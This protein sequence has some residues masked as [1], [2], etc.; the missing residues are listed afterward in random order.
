LDCN[1]SGISL[2][3]MDT[4]HVALVAMTLR[5]DGFDP[6][7]CDRNTT[8]GINLGTLSKVLKSAQNEDVLTIRTGSKPDV[9]NLT[10]ESA[11]SDRVGEYEVKLMDIDSEHLSVPDTDYAAEVILPSTEFL[12]ICR[13]FNGIAETITIGV[14]K[15]AVKFSCSGD[16]GNGQVTLKPHEVMDKPDDTVKIVHTQTVSCDFSLKYL[17]NFTKASPLAGS[18]K[19]SMGPDIPL[20]VSYNM[21]I[22]DLKFYLAPK[23]DEN[24]DDDE[25]HANGARDDDE[26]EEEEDVKMK[27]ERV[28]SEEPVEV[29]DD[30]DDDVKIEP[31]KVEDEDD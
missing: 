4:S 12:R 11:K 13:D 24:D 14:T 3:A 18:V 10:Y 25:P 30:D 15:N 8:L 29:V 22:G 19:L 9:L 6:Y 5:S 17:V 27:L 20:M 28:E 26:E 16:V 23:I 21:E 1:D 31:G 7:R 2:Q